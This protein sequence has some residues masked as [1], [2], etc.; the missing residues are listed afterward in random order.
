MCAP[1]AAPLH[2]TILSGHRPVG[3]P[4]NISAIPR[5][6]GTP[7][8]AG[9]DGADGR[10]VPSRRY[11][12]P[13]AAGAAQW[14]PPDPRTARHD[15]RRRADNRHMARRGDRPVFLR[16]ARHLPASA[17]PACR[18]RPE[19][20]ARRPR[21]LC[22]G[23]P[24]KVKHGCPAFAAPSCRRYSSSSCLRWPPFCWPTR[25]RRLGEP[26]TLCLLSMVL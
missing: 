8:E 5:R 25:R 17:A 15:R 20:A 24:L 21:I 2:H 26:R 23:G 14:A 7:R 18:P 13:P 6:L 12:P 3:G 4:F 22:S 9:A 16:P 1:A 19:P 10:G 11:G